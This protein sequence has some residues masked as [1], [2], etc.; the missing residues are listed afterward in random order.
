MRVN[1]IRRTFNEIPSSHAMILF[2]AMDITMAANTNREIEINLTIH[3]LALLCICQNTN[4]TIVTLISLFC[5]CRCNHVRRF[6]HQICS[7]LDN[8]RNTSEV[9]Q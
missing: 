4:Y 1:F 7:A 6:S 3:T 8:R 2:S 9:L 5:P